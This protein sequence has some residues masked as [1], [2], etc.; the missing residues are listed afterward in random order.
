MGIALCSLAHRAKK[1]MARS[2]V[3]FQHDAAR[4]AVS[5]HIVVQFCPNDGFHVFL[6]W[7]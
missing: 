7:N 6:R 4:M 5:L 3:P 2:S 1:S